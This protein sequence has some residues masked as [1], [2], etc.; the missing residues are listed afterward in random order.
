[1]PIRT[2]IV[3]NLRQKFLASGADT[4]HRSKFRISTNQTRA[5]IRITGD[6]V[7]KARPSATVMDMNAMTAVNST[8]PP[9]PV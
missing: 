2:T 4:S 6:R 8:A 5:G 9:M 3:G 7:S 1:M